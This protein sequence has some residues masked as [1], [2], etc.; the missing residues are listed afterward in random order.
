M[1]THLTAADITRQIHAGDITAQH[2]VEHTLERIDRA[3]PALHAFREIYA[4]SAHRHAA[5]IDARR[6][7]NEPLGP[8]AGVPI[9]LKDNIVSRHGTTAAGSRMLEHFSSPYDATVVRRL[10]DADAVIIGRTNCDEFAMGSSGEHCAFGPTAN[11]WDRTRVPGGSSSGSAG[12]VAAGL[13]PIA[14]GSDTG[15]SIRQPASF[16]G[17]IGFKPTYG[18]VSR[19]G[20]IA[21]GSSLDQ[22]GP[23]AR[24]LHDAA[25]VYTV[26]A[27]H[28]PL[29]ATTATHEVADPLAGAPDP[30]DAAGLRIGVA[31]GHRTDDNDPR[32]NAAVDRAL[33]TLR[34]A[35]ASI[36]EI[37]LPPADVSIATYYLIATAEASSNLARY[38]GI[39]YG[40]RATVDAHATLE[41]LYARSRSEGFG[42]EVKRRILL[43]TFVLSA[44]YADQYY[45]A[46]L[47]A[48]RWI[49]EAYARAFTKCDVILGPTTPTPAFPL[50]DK[51]DPLSMYLCDVYTVDVNIAGLCAMS[52]PGDTAGQSADRL[53]VG[54]HLCAAPFAESM[55]FHAA[56]CL[57]GTT[58]CAIAP[59]FR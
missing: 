17:L 9:A 54:V 58:S 5:E 7:R 4:E 49:A 57:A 36:I 14:I 37:E 26:I 41:T 43:G 23:F 27:G 12:A 1:T 11:P 32:V 10:L 22:I 16:C 45:T 48:R 38:D 34:E 44:G 39:R 33:D 21:F 8:L 25:A 3:N 53:P 56:N 31:P 46:A 59:D 24:T 18:R 35:G 47:K 55:L 15:G 30:T 52:I 50:G 20:L 42:A 19:S 13:V 2:A 40:Q 6:Q 51:P 28:D 29:D